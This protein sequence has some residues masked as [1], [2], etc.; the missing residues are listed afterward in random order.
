MTSTEKTRSRT[1]F[2]LIPNLVTI[3]SLCLTLTAIRMAF[4]QDFVFATSLLLIAG[5]MDGVDGRLA[6]FLNASSEFGAQLDSLIDFVNFGIVPGFIVYFWVNTYQDVKGFDW[7]MVL[8]FAVCMV[9]RLAR[10]NVD[11]NKKS[12]NPL[13]E[14]YFFKGIPAPVGAALSMLPMVLFY[15]FGEGFYTNPIL[16]ITYISVLAVFLASRVPTISIKKIPIRNEYAYLTLII[17]GSI[18]IGLIIKPWLTLAI[19]G[20]VYVLSIP[21]TIFY[22]IRIEI[23]ERFKN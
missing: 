13:L 17:L 8:F 16:V 1:L 11:L 14:K 7:A 5:F 15:E 20:I 21:I 2:S 6:R 9:I 22:Y 3:S 4:A 12:S 19:I 18:I 23:T 10:F